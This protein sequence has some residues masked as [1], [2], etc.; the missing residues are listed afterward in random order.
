LKASCPRRHRGGNYHD[1]YAIPK[2]S[3]TRN[4]VSTKEGFTTSPPILR[5]VSPLG[6]T[7]DTLLGGKLELALGADEGAVKRRLVNGFAEVTG[8]TNKIHRITYEFLVAHTNNKT[9]T[10]RIVFKE[11]TPQPRDERIVV[12]L[13]RS[14]ERKTEGSPGE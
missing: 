9:T 13:L 10:E 12:K 3:R 8:L 2:V 1:R 6:S 14:C 11:P 7:T 4:T 5:G